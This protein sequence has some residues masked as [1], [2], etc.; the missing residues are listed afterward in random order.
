MGDAGLVDLLR[1]KGA[2][3]GEFVMDDRTFIRPPGFY[4]RAAYFV[5][6]SQGL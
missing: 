4:R 2:K 5:D 1:V 3:H 6:S